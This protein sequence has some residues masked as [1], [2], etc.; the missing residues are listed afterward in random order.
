MRV[1]IIGYD[2]RWVVRDDTETPESE[3]V[4]I[5]IYPLVHEWIQQRAEIVRLTAL[6]TA[7][8]IPPACRCEPVE[9]GYDIH[10]MEPICDDYRP[11][12]DTKEWCYNCL[13]EKACHKEA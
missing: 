7:W 3:I 12:S 6:L 11:F 2:A 10:N 5:E 1:E 9:W 8:G 13:H 4:E